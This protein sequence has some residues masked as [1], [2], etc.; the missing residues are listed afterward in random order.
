MAKDFENQEHEDLPE[1]FGGALEQ[2]RISQ[3]RVQRVLNSPSLQSFLKAQKAIQGKTGKSF[4]PSAALLKSLAVTEKLEPAVVRFGNFS[5][6]PQQSLYQNQKLLQEASISM[7]PALESMRLAAEASTSIRPFLESM[8]SVGKSLASLT[9]PS[10]TLTQVVKMTRS[11]AEFE[12]LQQN[13]TLARLASEHFSPALLQFSETAELQRSAI[14]SA[15]GSIDQIMNRSFSAAAFSMESLHL[16]ASQKALDNLTNTFQS[17]AKSLSCRKNQLAAAQRQTTQSEVTFSQGLIINKA[18]LKSNVMPLESNKRSAISKAD[19][20]ASEARLRADISEFKAE[21]RADIAYLR[22][23]QIPVLQVIESDG[24]DR[25][26]NPSSWYLL[27]QIEIR[28]RKTIEQRLTE[29]S[30]E[31]WIRQRVPHDIRERW[32]QRQEEDRRTNRPVYSL[33]QYADFMDLAS[34]IVRSDNW[35]EVFKLIFK[36]KEEIQISLQRLHPI[37]KSIAHS[38]PLSKPDILTLA[39]EA[40]RIFSALGLKFS[41]EVGSI[42]FRPH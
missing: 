20:Q 7:K 2:I 29:L 18:V 16:S 33:I 14:E 19:I 9:D 32:K 5:V 1:V 8:K 10:A 6:L 41:L 21:V 36:T 35:R 42:Y 31:N 23:N 39:S 25:F 15:R 24:S 4:C 17:S 22:Q 37:R 11:F 3:Q 40:S 34:I 26:L 12:S 38:R 30:G 13:A 27:A 28:L